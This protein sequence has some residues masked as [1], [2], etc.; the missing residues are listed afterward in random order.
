MTTTDFPL[1]GAPWF[2]KDRWW[3]SPM[4]FDPE[5]QESLPERIRIHDVTLRDGEQTP[6]VVYRNEER[7]AVAQALDDLGV[8]RIEVGMPII[9]SEVAQGCA[10]VNKLGLKA[11][12][13]GFARAHPRDIEVCAET[14]FGTVIIEHTVNPH[15]CKHVYNVDRSQLLE[16]LSESFAE[17]RRQGLKPIFMGWDFFR[18]TL[19]YLL[20]L[21][22]ELVPRIHPE[23]LV[24]VDTFGVATPRA[25]QKAFEVFKDRYGTLELEFH[26]HDDFGQALGAVVA[27][28]QGGASVVHTS[29]NGLGERTGNAPTEQV[30]AAMEMLLGVDTG[31]RM[32]RLVSTSRLV[33]EVSKVSIPFNAPIVGRRIFE[34]ETG[35]A[36]HSAEK[37]Q[38][39]GIRPTRTFVPE[40]V[41]QPDIAILLGAGSGSVSIQYH[42]KRLGVELSTEGA[43]KVLDEVKRESTIRKSLLDE[44]TFR[45]IVAGVAAADR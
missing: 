34:I 30:V 35:V 41:G 32:K 22:D 10:Q 44:E 25:V 5:I 9:S 33:E 8:D 15:L 18:C 20:D 19:D 21:Y 29:M 36:V 12:L 27:A 26:N 13:V 38:G 28:V 43:K 23:A 40:V 45:Q 6:G 31:I 17:S 7:L 37:L 3:V 24:L 42:L 16:R 2:D 39:Q 11:E 14:G 1:D 4:N